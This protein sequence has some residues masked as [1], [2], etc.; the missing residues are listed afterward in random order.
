MPMAVHHQLM[1]PMAHKHIEHHHFAPTPAMGPLVMPLAA[2]P[3]YHG[4]AYAHL[5]LVGH[6][7][8]VKNVQPWSMGYST[9]TQPEL[10][11]AKVT[12]QYTT[13]GWTAPLA[14]EV[15]SQ[16]VKFD[17]FGSLSTAGKVNVDSQNSVRVD[18]SFE[19]ISQVKTD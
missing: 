12:K 10:H 19:G 5:P 13:G 2:N 1:M 14:P 18:K 17:R 3:V 8:F 15:D 6:Q 16:L 7:T 11:V 4:A 9:Y